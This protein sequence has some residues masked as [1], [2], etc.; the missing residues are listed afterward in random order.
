MTTD[1]RYVE[2]YMKYS[3]CSYVLRWTTILPW[4]FGH[5]D[6]TISFTLISKAML[7]YITTTVFLQKCSSTTLF[8]MLQYIIA[9]RQSIELQISFQLLFYTVIWYPSFYEHS[10]LYQQWLW[11]YLEDRSD[12]YSSPL[13]VWCTAATPNTSKDR[14]FCVCFQVPRNQLWVSSIIRN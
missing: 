10:R 12:E 2:H 8:D 7:P 11:L 5:T 1:S 13:V 6:S 4:N 9:S 14:D 3:I